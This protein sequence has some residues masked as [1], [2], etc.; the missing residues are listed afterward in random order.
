[1]PLQ[2]AYPLLLA[3]A[4]FAVSAVLS[5]RAVT[6]MSAEAKAALLDASSRTGLLSLLAVGGFVALVLWRPLVAWVFLGSA[7]LA[8]GVRSYFRLRHL[9]L[10]PPAARLILLANAAAVG[11]IAACALIF[12]LRALG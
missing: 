7:Y 6:L 3:F 11:G 4:G 5:K 12:A 8:L 10:P 2:T 1:M 9:R